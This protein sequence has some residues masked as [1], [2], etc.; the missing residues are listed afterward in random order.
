MHVKRCRNYSACKALCLVRGRVWKTSRFAVFLEFAEV[1]NL[2]AL[3]EANIYDSS[4]RRRISFVYKVIRGDWNVCRKLSTNWWQKYTKSLRIFIK[5]SFR[6]G[7]GEQIHQITQV[8][9]SFSVSALE[10]NEL[11]F[12]HKSR[13]LFYSLSLRL[14]SQSR[15][16]FLLVL[17]SFTTKPINSHLIFVFYTN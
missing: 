9:C 7:F 13:L 17:V 11:W 16:F 12:L 15:L 10:I 6:M 8:Y 14:Q 5:N 4:A 3:G 1:A 2:A